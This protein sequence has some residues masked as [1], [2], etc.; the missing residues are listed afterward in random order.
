VHDQG[1]LGKCRVGAHTHPKG[2]GLIKG[3]SGWCVVCYNGRGN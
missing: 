1:G 2:W 3:T